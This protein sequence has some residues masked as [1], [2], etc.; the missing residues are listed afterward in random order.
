MIP[1]GVPPPSLADVRPINE[2]GLPEK[3]RR[4]LEGLRA[5]VVDATNMARVLKSSRTSEVGG[6]YAGTMRAD[7]NRINK[8]A[9]YSYIPGLT[10][11]GTT[12]RVIGV[13]APGE[14]SV[15][16]NTDGEGA[17]GKITVRIDRTKNRISQLADIVFCKD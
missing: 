3:V 5:T 4:T 10:V 12:R 11:T 13:P 6:L 15:E 14:L 9:G 16:V 8:L 1:N 2:D 7:L 17:D